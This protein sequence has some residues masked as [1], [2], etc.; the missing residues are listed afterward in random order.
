VS[1]GVDV[2]AVTA[3]FGINPFALSSKAPTQPGPIKALSTIA[4]LKTII[5]FVAGRIAKQM[6]K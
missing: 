3:L 1:G 5:S 4:L 6:D 2:N